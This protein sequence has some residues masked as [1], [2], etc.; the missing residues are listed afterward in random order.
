MDEKVSPFPLVRE[1]LVAATPGPLGTWVVLALKQIASAVLGEPIE[2]RELDTDQATRSFLTERPEGPVL[3]VTHFPRPEL[4]NYVARNETPIIVAIDNPSYSVAVHVKDGSLG[5]RD[6]VKPVTQSL[7]LLTA[8][9]PVERSVLLST[10]DY[11]RP[12]THVVASLAIALGVSREN[13]GSIARAFRGWEV[14]TLARSIER[15]VFHN[16]TFAELDELISPSDGATIIRS[17][18]GL[19]DRILGEEPEEIVW[20]REF[21]YDGTTL[22][23]P[24]PVTVDM[25]GPA[26]C[27]FYGP[28]LHL[29]VGRWEAR[30][31][32][33]FSAQTTDTWLKVDLYTDDVQAIFY[34]RVKRGGVYAMPIT[35]DVSDPR[36]PIQIRIFIERGEID[37]QMGLGVVRLKRVEDEPNEQEDSV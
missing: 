25:T 11:H 9:A 7:S 16:G 6:A 15:H 10:G 32:L 34:S 26:R 2:V 12:V 19:I 22:T 28:Y 31:L 3:L 1:L 4:V 33:G 21:F 14:T 35:F 5:P 37:G 24:P 20:N 36:Q 17:T 18:K 23:S 8:L 29:P 30:L 27:L 13:I